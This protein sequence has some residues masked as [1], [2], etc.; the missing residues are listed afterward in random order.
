MS[1]RRL[2]AI[3]PCTVWKAPRSCTSP[4]AGT[5]PT[6]S[7]LVKVRLRLG[8]AWLMGMVEPWKRNGAVTQ[9]PRVHTPSPLGNQSPPVAPGG[10]QS[11]QLRCDLRLE[12]QAG[13][14]PEGQG[15]CSTLSLAGRAFGWKLVLVPAKPLALA[16]EK[17]RVRVGAGPGAPLP[18]ALSS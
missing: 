15:V 2:C 8:L 6:G 7:F 5:H 9:G 11:H 4:W 10:S 17:E 3:A 16:L 13:G 1:S 14:Q 12:R 18:T